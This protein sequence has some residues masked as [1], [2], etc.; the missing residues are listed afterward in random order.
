MVHTAT[1]AAKVYADGIT[2]LKKLKAPDDQADD[3]AKLQANFQDQVEV[4]DQIG[5]AAKKDDAATVT[6]KLTSLAK[7][8]EEN[9][10]LADSLDAKPCAL[11]AVFTE[12]PTA[13]TTTTKPASTP[14]TQDPANPTSSST[15]G[16]SAGGTSAGGS[17]PPADPA[18]R[19]R[20]RCGRPCS[21][22]T[23]RGSPRRPP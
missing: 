22:P 14:A 6:T 1:D 5:T 17:A 7:I 18:A 3:F 10:K 2:A 19:W 21:C 20:R 9:V 15:G 4:F 13:A 16:T 23:R 12:Q 8:N 11:P